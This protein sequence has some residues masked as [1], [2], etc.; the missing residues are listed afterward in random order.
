[1]RQKDDMLR[2]MKQELLMKKD[3]LLDVE[4]IYF[5][6]G[7][8]SLLNAIEIAQFINLIHNNFDLYK[9]A[10]ITLEMNPDDCSQDY[11]SQI[12]DIGINR[13]S[14]GIQSFQTHDLEYMNR[15]HNVKQSHQAIQFCRTAGFD[16]I[17]IDLIY[18]T[19]GLTDEQWHENL[20]IAADY[21]VEHL[22]CYQLTIEEQTPLHALIAKQLKASPDESAFVRQF[23]ILMDF[24][25]VHDYLQYEISNF[26]KAGYQSKHNSSYW[27]NKIYLGIGP[28][29]H[30]YDGEQRA[31]NVANNSKYIRGIE[32]LEN[33][34]QIEQLSITDRFN[35]YVLIQ[36]RQAVGIEKEIVQSNF[37]KYFAKLQKK[38][39]THIQKGHL[40]ETQTHFYL[41]RSGKLWADAIS[42]DL[43][44]A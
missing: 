17:S 8:P 5:G 41:S 43:F 6:G 23:E 20:G 27:Q 34:G 31:W 35:E 21:E 12:R 26:C 9:D 28:S 44:V 33:I 13:I 18:G 2:C 40:I 24:A 16:N 39:Q 25:A 14:L 37:P 7:T 19:P 42:L 1:M 22:S 3:R 29:A 11:L 38:A 4:T 36:L 32:N 30:S 10:E 15:I